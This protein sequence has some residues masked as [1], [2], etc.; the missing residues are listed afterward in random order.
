MRVGEAFATLIPLTLALSREGRGEPIRVRIF[1]AF[2]LVREEITFSAPNSLL[3]ATFVGFLMKEIPSLE[4]SQPPADMVPLVVDLDGTL[5]KTDLLVESFFSLLKKNPLYILAFLFWL[6]KGKAFLK[7]QV[8]RRVAFDVDVL[9][10][11][12]ELLDHLKGQHARGRPLVLAT[13]NDERIASQ[14]A[15][16]LQIFD[17][18]LASNGKVNLSRRHK[19]E[20]LVQVFGEKGFDY[21]GNGRYD[22]E[23][24][25]A[26]RKALIVNCPQGVSRKA[27]RV[28]EVDRVFN[29]REGKIIACLRACRPQHWLKNLLVF[30]PLVMAHRYNEPDLLARAFLSFVAFGLCASSVY[31]INDLVDLP[32]D[33]HHPRKRQRPFL[34]PEPEA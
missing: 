28:V 3:S 9:P 17:R 25:S 5:V 16:H 14:V 21:A 24:W 23:V 13:A 34:L 15:D 33:R 2:V 6:L 12:H 29:D 30:V 4:K 32:A 22:L 10:Y 20:R 7:Q 27:A 11:N 1:D 18:V 8:V 31:I 19:R 26:A